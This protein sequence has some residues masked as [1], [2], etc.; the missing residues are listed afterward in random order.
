[1]LAPPPSTGQS[2]SAGGSILSVGIC[3]WIVGKPETIQKRA[4]GKCCLPAGSYKLLWQLGEK[5]HGRKTEQL[6]EIPNVVRFRPENLFLSCDCAL[7]TQSRANLLRFT[8]PLKVATFSHRIANHSPF[9]VDRIANGN[10]TEREVRTAR[11]AAGFSAV[12]L[13]SATYGHVGI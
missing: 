10:R 12:V 8:K 6:S 5:S 2:A 3:A 7:G 13:L 9:G 4:S 1:V 11:F